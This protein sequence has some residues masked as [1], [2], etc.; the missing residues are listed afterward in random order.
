MIPSEYNLLHCESTSSGA[1]INKSETQDAFLESKRVPAQTPVSDSLSKRTVE[2]KFTNN[3]LGSSSFSSVFFDARSQEYLLLVKAMRVMEKGPT[4][5]DD[6]LGPVSRKKMTVSQL[7]KKKSE[8]KSENDKKLRELGRLTEQISSDISNPR[9]KIRQQDVICV[10]EILSDFHNHY[11]FIQ[12]MFFI[13]HKVVNDYCNDD[14]MLFANAIRHKCGEVIELIY[15]FLL[16]RDDLNIVPNFRM[17]YA[18]WDLYYT[19]NIVSCCQNIDGSQH[20]AS[21]FNPELPVKFASKIFR[22]FPDLT[23]LEREFLE[24]KKDKKSGDDDLKIQTLHFSLLTGKDVNLE[25]LI[26][27]IKTGCQRLQHTESSNKNNVMKYYELLQVLL[28]ATI[29]ALE[30]SD[31]DARRLLACFDYFFFTI[32]SARVL[33]QY[34]LAKCEEKSGAIDAASRIYQSLVSGE[35]QVPVFEELIFCLEKLGDNDAVVQTC[36]SAADYYRYK[37]IKWREEYYE[38]KAASYMLMANKDDIDDIKGVDHSSGQD[39]I[40]VSSVQPDVEPQA[41]A[42]GSKKYKSNRKNKAKRGAEN[43]TTSLHS[44]R[45]AEKTESVQSCATARPCS[46]GKVEKDTAQVM[47]SEVLATD[48]PEPGSGKSGRDYWRELNEMFLDYYH[49]P[50]KYR[51]AVESLSRE[52]CQVFPKDIWILHSAG[53]GFHLIGDEQKAAEL[54]LKGLRQYLDRHY[55]EVKS[56]IPVNIYGNVETGLDRLKAHP[57]ITPGSPAGLNVAAYL[58]S[59]AYVYRN[60]NKHCDDQMRSLANWLNPSRDA[61]KKEKQRVSFAAKVNVIP[62]E[63]DLVTRR[64]MAFGHDYQE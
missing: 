36:M 25:M 50:H 48:S 44:S 53:W 8:L 22:R 37:G 13:I 19:Y 55:P 41:K 54:L 33:K 47:L 59:L 42:V 4:F 32:F 11:H 12:C 64:F 17:L 16:S 9:K 28:S 21:Y 27:R 30:R 15:K 60:L 46:A 62:A 24:L 5:N 29:C 26:S 7:R 35:N 51:D 34:M 23:E 14:E 63:V 40:D 2:P 56:F 57:E 43:H 18:V 31:Q 58:S 3:Y 38:H 49:L 52:A 10:L 6:K 20:C 45:P 1:G 61:R 39:G